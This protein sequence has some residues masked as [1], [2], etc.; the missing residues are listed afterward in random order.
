MLTNDE[1]IEF[2]EL[3][4]RCNTGFSIQNSVFLQLLH[5]IDRNPSN[6]NMVQVL[7]SGPKNAGHWIA[8]YY[9]GEILHIYDG[10]GKGLNKEHKLFIKYIS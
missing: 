3:L 5:Y 6:K 10:M 2:N 7:F 1:M 9:D 8:V 4:I